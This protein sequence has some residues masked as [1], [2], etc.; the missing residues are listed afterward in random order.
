MI[1][2]TDYLIAA[3]VGF[4]VGIFI[5]PILVNIGIKN[6]PV[7]MLLPIVLPLLWI[8]GIWLGKFLSRWLPFMGQ[9]SKFV[10][11]GFLNTA[12]DFGILNL[13]SAV[14]DVTKGLVVGGVNI[15]GFA[16]AVTNAYLWNKLW[17]FKNRDPGET[18]FHDFPKFLAVTGIGLFLNSLVVVVVTTYISPLFGLGPEAWLNVSKAMATAIVMFWN[19]LGYKLIVFSPEN[20]K[21]QV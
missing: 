14:G 18:L 13:L 3:L 15:P 4:L 9:F 12:I 21:P 6:Y 5:I 7:L 19:F 11:V 2:K 1:T 8:F 20:A 10:A 17:V 16:V